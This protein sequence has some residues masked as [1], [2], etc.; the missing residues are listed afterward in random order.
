MNNSELKIVAYLKP[1]CGWS[2]GVRA[3]LEK[4]GLSYEERDII[5]DPMQRMEMVQ[6]AVRSFRHAWK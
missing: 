3:V 5:N 4:H 1:W 6:K 2:K